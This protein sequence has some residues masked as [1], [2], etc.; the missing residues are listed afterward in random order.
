MP[1][2]YSVDLRERVAGFV[3]GVIPACSSGSFRRV[4]AL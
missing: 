3:D 1:K 2:P 4:S